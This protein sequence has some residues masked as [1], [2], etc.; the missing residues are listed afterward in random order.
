M[1]HST[2]IV[3]HGFPRSDS[4]YCARMCVLFLEFA[5]ANSSRCG[6]AG[7]RTCVHW[8]ERGTARALHRIFIVVMHLLMNN[9]ND[10]DVLNKQ[11]LHA[12][13]VYSF[14]HYYQYYYH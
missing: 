9:N 11:D 6:W 5:V 7:G 2:N 12:I 4:G 8:R 10:G 3:V 1:Q 14:T 13:Q